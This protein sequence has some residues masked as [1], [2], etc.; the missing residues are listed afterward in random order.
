MMGI[1]AVL[2]AAI[3]FAVP[4]ANALGAIEPVGGTLADD[5]PIEVLDA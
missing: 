2:G 4:P 3:C 5:E 1:G